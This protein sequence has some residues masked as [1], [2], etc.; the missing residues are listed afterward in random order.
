MPRN[1]G[2]WLRRQHFDSVKE[3][4]DE[5]CFLQSVEEE[6]NCGSGKIFTVEREPLEEG[7][8]VEIKQIVKDCIK[9]MQAQQLKK[10]QSER[11]RSSCR[12]LWVLV[13]QGKRTFNERVSSYAAGQNCSL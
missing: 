7:L 11:P 10:E 3:A 8:K 6:E 2:Q 13:L 12:K 5:A 9:E 1:I 4:L